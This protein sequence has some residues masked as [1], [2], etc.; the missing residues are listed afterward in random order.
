[1]KR[2]HIEDIYELS[3]LQQGMLFHTLLTPGSG[4]YFEQVAFPLYGPLNTA[5]FERS[6]Q[7]VLD[8]HTILRTSF[9]W[10]KV[11]KPLQVVYRKVKLPMQ[12][13]DWSGLSEVE[14]SER[15]ESLLRED[16][17][18]G[19]DL[20]EAPLLR[21]SVIVKGRNSRVILFSLHH[22]LLDGWS[23]SLVYKEARAL[24]EA[25]CRDE[26]LQLPKC[27]PYGD[28]IA[29]L[30]KQDSD[31]AEEYWRR[32][33]RGYSGPPPFGVG[34]PPGPQHEDT[35]YDVCESHV[36]ATI[37]D[38]LRRLA[39]THRLTLN[40]IVQ[41]AWALLLSRYSGTE[42]VVL[43]ATVSGRPAEL[44]GIES[45]IGLFINTLPVRIRV[46]PTS[47]LLD[48]LRELQM[49]QA[50][51][52][53][54]EHVALSQ[55]H[56]WSDV[57]PEA[58]LF[59]T[60]IGFENFPAAGGGSS[61][62]GGSEVRL[63]S[64]TNFPLSLAV[65]P[66]AGDFGLKLIY[67]RPRFEAAAMNRLLNHFQQLLTSIAGKPAGRLADI[68]MLTDLEERQLIKWNDTATNYPRDK[69]IHE[70]FE[71][72]VERTPDAVAITVEGEHLSYAALNRRA[73]RLARHLRLVGVGPETVVA[74]CGESP[75]EV[76]TAM[77]GV[78]KAGGAYVPLDQSYPDERLVFM[79]QDCEAR[80][81]VT[82][83]ALAGK[84]SA[85]GV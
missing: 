49:N 56:S 77:L 44:E 31:A 20:S 32:R 72:Q 85:E 78:L 2:D 35:Q 24:Y 29:W 65:I 58:P 12:Y 69:T 63:F 26:E 38:A 18:R 57:P 84:I 60:I 43:G 6:W 70:L 55:I 13:V 71:G 30:Q 14:F 74:L 19:F 15:L 23:S 73:N 36:P 45:M 5:A 53:Q 62:N 21:L 54:F 1:M 16:R 40:T 80:V 52:R 33:L 37:T 76:V 81:L 61:S 82:S 27:R 9:H 17:E 75:I 50:E 28:Y 41:G 3:P 39:R 48:W 8:R 22:L 25:H 10:T 34:L 79:L 46:S 47:Y 4:M 67:A 68:A 66:G 11:A 59:E 7:Q 51:A 64:Q 42:D 83:R